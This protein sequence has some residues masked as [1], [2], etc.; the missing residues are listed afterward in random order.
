VTVRLEKERGRGK[1]VDYK[2][3]RAKRLPVEESSDLMVKVKG[4]CRAEQ[5]LEEVIVWW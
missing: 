3:A 1:I 4:D 2:G 5:V